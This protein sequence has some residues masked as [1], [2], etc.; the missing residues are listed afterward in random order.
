MIVL[1]VTP[2]FLLTSIGVKS[3]TRLWSRKNNNLIS[4]AAERIYI[5]TE[6][7]KQICHIFVKGCTTQD[8][9][10]LFGAAEY[11]EKSEVSP[12]SSVMCDSD[13]CSKYNMILTSPDCMF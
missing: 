3:N 4:T 7:N 10:D 5:V 12:V 8:Y 1:F 9:S 11:I 2:I 6:N 13:Q